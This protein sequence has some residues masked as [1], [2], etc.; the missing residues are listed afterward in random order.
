MEDVLDPYEE[1]PDPE[2][3][4]VCFAEYPCQL[5]EEVRPPEPA[6]GPR[7]RRVDYEYR[8]NGT[9]NLFLVVHPEAGGRHV[10]ATDRR[11]KMDFAA[12]MKALVDEQFPAAKLIQVVLDNLNTHTP[13]AL[14]ETFA[15]EEAGRTA[16]TLEFRYTAKPGS[17]LN[18]AE[19]ELAA[20]ATQCPGRCIPDAA[21]PR[22]KVDAW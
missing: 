14:Y 6:Q 3:A 5:V 10:Q 13:A 22:R 17:W 18:M 7:P 4:V 12:R 2:Q 11:T 19:L 1:S 9:A 20:L 21:S 15:P 8:R 16:R